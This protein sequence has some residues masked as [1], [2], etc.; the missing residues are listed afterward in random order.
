MNYL[1]VARQ[2]QQLRERVAGFQLVLFGAGAA[3]EQILLLLEALGIQCAFF[4]DNDPARWQQLVAGRYPVKAPTALQH[5]PEQYFILISSGA[6][7]AIRQQLTELGF[8]REQQI[9][10]A[11][12]PDP[13]LAGRQIFS[14]LYPDYATALADSTGYQVDSYRTAALASR[15][16]FLTQLVAGRHRL[17]ID[18]QQM[19]LAVLLAATAQEADRSGK[20]ALRVLD[21]GGALGEHFHLIRHFAPQIDIAL[22]QICETPLLVDTA[23][24][25]AHPPALQFCRELPAQPVDLVIASGSLQ[26]VA[27]PAQSFAALVALEAPFVYISRFPLWPGP[28]DVVARLDVPAHLFNASYPSWHLSLTQWQP[29]FQQ[30][31]QIRASWLNPEFYYQDQQRIDFYGFLLQRQQTSSAKEQV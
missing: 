31:H 7:A 17:D 28:N 2:L 6:G 20:R 25:L 15:E 26:F 24:G 4:V 10:N 21:F 9:L 16:A 30:A 12:A 29:R 14:A 5:Q 11:I 1:H 19:L 13:S 22:W 23:A 8:H 27:E 3:G 18:E